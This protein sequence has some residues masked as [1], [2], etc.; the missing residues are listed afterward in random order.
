MF[1]CLKRKAKKKKEKRIAD[2]NLSQL[3][4]RIFCRNVFF[5]DCTNY[6]LEQKLLIISWEIW[7]YSVSLVPSF[8]LVPAAYWS[9]KLCSDLSSVH[10]IAERFSSMDWMLLGIELLGFVQ[11]IKLSHGRMKSCH[12][13]QHARDKRN[14][15]QKGFRV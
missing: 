7:Q 6:P 1:R 8:L 11:K 3:V 4:A 9:W 13:Q 15:R 5:Q 10:I 12:Q 14:A 2:I